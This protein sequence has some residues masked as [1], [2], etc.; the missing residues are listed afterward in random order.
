MADRKHRIVAGKWAGGKR[1]LRR[2]SPL[3]ESSEKRKTHSK[4]EVG[5]KMQDEKD[6]DQENKQTLR[7]SEE[8]IKEDEEGEIEENEMQSKT[9]QKA[10]KNK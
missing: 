8:G 2:K 6:I 3:D 1:T 7:W 4:T 10:N 5:E 9:Y